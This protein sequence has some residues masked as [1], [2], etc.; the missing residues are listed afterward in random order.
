MIIC[1]NTKKKNKNFL[2]G[3]TNVVTNIQ[4]Q[5]T[6]TKNLIKI[7]KENFKKHLTYE[8]VCD[9]IISR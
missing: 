2:I 7:L 3:Y 9:I 6:K 8:V 5:K 4:S 1:C